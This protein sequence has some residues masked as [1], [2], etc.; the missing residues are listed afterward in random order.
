MTTLPR[1]PGAPGA[2]G[3]APCTENTR[4]RHLGA[5]HTTGGASGTEKAVGGGDEAADDR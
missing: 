2:T 3:G 4:L 1:R 5:P